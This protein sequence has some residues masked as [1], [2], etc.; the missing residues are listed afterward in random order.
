M[1]ETLKKGGKNTPTERQQSGE[2]L[3]Y[4]KENVEHTSEAPAST[5]LLQKHIHTEN[6]QRMGAGE[7]GV[8]RKE[9]QSIY[10]Y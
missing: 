10:F 5:A 4:R 6:I 1:K 3:L 8:G 9:T 2:H 7:E